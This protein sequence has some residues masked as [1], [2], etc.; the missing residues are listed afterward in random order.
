MGSGNLED[1]DYGYFEKCLELGNL[2]W[3]MRPRDS[4]IGIARSHHRVRI[5]NKT[6][7]DNV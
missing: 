4:L 6:M 3:K 1:D 2:G 5:H 7:L